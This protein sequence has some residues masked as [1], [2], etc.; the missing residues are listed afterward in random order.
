MEKMELLDAP[1]LCPQGELELLSMLASAEMTLAELC[2]YMSLR[3]R[4]ES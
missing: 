4:K 2:A 3:D 1:E